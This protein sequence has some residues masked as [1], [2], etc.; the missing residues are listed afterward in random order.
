MELEDKYKMKIETG[1][2]ICNTDKIRLINEKVY[3][4]PV[5]LLP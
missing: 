5:Y 4:V 1:L 3:Q 2:I